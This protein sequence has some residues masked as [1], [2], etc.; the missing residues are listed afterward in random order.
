MEFVEG[1]DNKVGG[2]FDRRVRN[3]A[4]R[5]RKELFIGAS[6]ISTTATDMTINSWHE[7]LE[8][9]A[10]TRRR[11]ER[12]VFGE[13]NM[14]DEVV[15]DGGEFFKRHTNRMACK[16]EKGAWELKLINVSIN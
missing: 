2:L 4:A 5:N 6:D 7:F 10:C 12:K 14:V 11:S 13:L 3:V 1:L 9:F 8:L 15:T 16:D